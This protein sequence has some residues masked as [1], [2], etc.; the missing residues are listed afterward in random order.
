[1]MELHSKRS[2]ACK[3]APLCVHGRRK[4]YCAGYGGQGICQHDKRRSLCD[5]CM[6][7]HLGGTG[8]CNKQDVEK[9]SGICRSCKAISPW[10]FSSAIELALDFSTRAI[11][12]AVD[13]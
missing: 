3:K 6:N 9:V 10:I 13:R 1:M 12:Y 11:W 4:Y 2:I 5:K 7:E 8:T